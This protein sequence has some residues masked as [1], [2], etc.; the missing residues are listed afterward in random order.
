M[1]SR[2]GGA[3]GRTTTCLTLSPASH[4]LTLPKKTSATLSLMIRYPLTRLPTQNLE[5]PFLT[6]FCLITLHQQ[7][8]KAIIRSGPCRLYLPTLLISQQNGF[9]RHLRQLSLL[10]IGP[11]MSFPS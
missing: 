5:D 9:S 4:A 6:V 7:V 1:T 2:F 11:R 10:T 8:S 3:Q